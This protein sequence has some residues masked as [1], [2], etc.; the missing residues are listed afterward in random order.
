MDKYMVELGCHMSQLQAPAEE[1]DYKNGHTALIGYCSGEY[2]T[3]DPWK[4]LYYY[5]CIQ[6]AVH[7]SNRY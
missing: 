1:L 6:A 4:T 2:F 5:L 3:D 7:Q